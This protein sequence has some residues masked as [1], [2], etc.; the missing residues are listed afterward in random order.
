MRFPKQARSGNCVPE[1]AL[2]LA[3]GFPIVALWETASQIEEQGRVV[4]GV[5]FND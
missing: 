4:I 2:K 3:P 5:F 1:S